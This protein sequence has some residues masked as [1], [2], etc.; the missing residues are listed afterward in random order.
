MTDE[1]DDA[2]LGTAPELAATIAQVMADIDGVPKTGYNDFHNYEYSTDDDVMG[3]LRPV[4]AKHGLVALPDLVSRD[5]QRFGSEAEGYT[6]HTRIVLDITLIDS[7]SGQQRTMRWEGEAQDTQDKGLYKAY[8]SAIKYFMLKTF[9][10]SADTDVE[11]D[12]IAGKQGASSPPPQGDEVVTDVQVP[13]E[14]WDSAESMPN[15][16]FSI[17]KDALIEN[18]VQPEG[19]VD[20]EKEDGTWLITAEGV[21]QSEHGEE[22]YRAMIERITQKIAAGEVQREAVDT[23]GVPKSEP[24]DEWP[25]EYREDIGTVLDPST[26]ESGANEEAFED[27][28]ESEQ[29][30]L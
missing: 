6:L 19:E 7:D 9:L 30:P 12:D 16:D 17:L 23:S 11:T 29:F 18:G 24:I 3:A 8:T 13:V 22:W 15:R 26:N 5:V 25:D 1:I 14:F 2:G 21:S 4:M 10:L 28:A 20:V 27:G